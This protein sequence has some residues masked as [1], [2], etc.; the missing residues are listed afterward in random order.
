MASEDSI[1]FRA[2]IEDSGLFT[3]VIEGVKNVVEDLSLAI[4][5]SGI[6]CT[7]ADEAL[8]NLVDINFRKE[9]CVDFEGRE[10]TQLGLSLDTLGK[11]LKVGFPQDQLTIQNFEGNEN[12]LVK[13]ESK[14]GDRTSDFE[15]R[16]LS[17]EAMDMIQPPPINPD[18]T[19]EMN[20]S[21]LR[22]LVGNYAS[23]NPTGVTFTVSG[24]ELKM[25]LHGVELLDGTVAHSVAL[26]EGH[27]L[28]IEVHSDAESMTQTFDLRS[29]VK[30]CKCG[31]LCS[32]TKL[33]FQDDH[34][35]IIEYSLGDLGHLRFYVAQKEQPQTQMDSQL[36]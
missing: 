21:V 31:G 2:V 36:S 32:T 4:T 11:A 6:R 1:L 5:E 9:G 3:K 15:V 12:L 30:F 22:N 24:G 27:E 35:A 8:A 13:F 23:M 33:F 29:W 17:T 25:T 7:G 18:F 16:L 10:S 34:P 20:S 19:V 26:E 14:Y 28:Q